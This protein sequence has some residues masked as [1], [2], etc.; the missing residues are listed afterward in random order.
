VGAAALDIRAYYEEAALSLVEHV[1]AA[2]QAGSWLYRMTEAGQPL[3]GASDALR[4]AAA[5]RAAWFRMVPV[6]RPDA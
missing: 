4:E 3:V 5:P 6:G 1:P 2:R